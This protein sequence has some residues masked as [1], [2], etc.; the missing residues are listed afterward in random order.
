MFNEATRRFIAENAAADVRRL[1]LRGVADGEVDLQGALLQIA[2]RQKMRHKVPLWADNGDV[3]F[4]PQL[5]LEQCSGQQAAGYKRSV[6]ERIIGTV[7][8]SLAQ[9]APERPG[10]RLK[11]MVLPTLTDL[12][13]GM[14][15]D[16]WQLSQAFSSATYVDFSEQLC[17]LA[18]HNFDALGLRNVSVVCARAEDYLRQMPPATMVFVDPARRDTA[19]RR[20]YGI[21]DC[22]PDVLALLPLLAEKAD[23]VM[24]KLSPMLDWHKALDDL[25]AAHVSEIHIVSVGGECKELLFVLRQS[26]EALKLFCAD[27][28][29]VVVFSPTEDDDSGEPADVS[30]MA[31]ASRL[32]VGKASDGLFLCVPN[33]SVMKSG[34]FRGLQRQTAT[35]QLAPGSH[36][37]L[38]TSMPESF[39]GRVFSVDS[40][41][42]LNKKEARAS[43]R[44]VTRA[45]VSV[46]NFPL[47][48]EALR[49]RLKLAD[50][51]EVFLFGTTLYDGSH[52][53][54]RTR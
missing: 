27:D 43:L 2:G 21:A 23:V 47:S 53:V 38:A 5:S 10:Q 1:A 52:V 6:A 24:L 28:D 4:P 13:G 41:F 54:V 18:R 16:F 46:R 17:A 9:T 22:T 36:L 7:D 15:V 19:G 35:V 11:S 12:T 31:E 50:G 25:S 37:F 45:N 39:P 51:G 26:D 30:A 49:R 8:N 3:L 42:S 48:A 33:A 14:G 29:S 44:D 32:L 40:V 20:T 34:C